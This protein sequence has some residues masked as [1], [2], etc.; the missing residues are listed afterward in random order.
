MHCPKIK[1]QDEK[2]REYARRSDHENW[3]ARKG[4]VEEA[5]WNAWCAGEKGRDRG[6]GSV[7]NILDARMDGGESIREGGG[8]DWI[9]SRALAC[10]LGVYPR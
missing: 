1:G 9:V 5:G 8:R 4:P 2:Q 3:D 6:L 7:S 10:C